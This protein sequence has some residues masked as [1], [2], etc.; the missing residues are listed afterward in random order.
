MTDGQPVFW[1]KVDLPCKVVC[2]RTAVNG[3]A[4]S[5]PVDTVELF[6][7]AVDIDNGSL[8]LNVGSLHGEWVWAVG[9]RVRLELELP[10]RVDVAKP[11]AMIVR[12]KV[13]R[14]HDMP[15]GTTRVEF[16]FRK[17]RFRDRNEL[18]PVAVAAGLVM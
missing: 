13:A 5:L 15:D 16:K 14:V 1:T 2:E 12:A 11:K 17:P 9:Q 7:T 6:G 3:L 8:S 18:Y 10:V 4:A